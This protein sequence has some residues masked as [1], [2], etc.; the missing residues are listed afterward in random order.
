M[1]NLQENQ[2]YKESFQN[3]QILLPDSDNIKIKIFF[4]LLKSLIF[5]FPKSNVQRFEKSLKFYLGLINIDDCN[6][7]QKPT[8][9]LYLGLPSKPWYEPDDYEVFKIVT[10]TLEEGAKD[11]KSELLM[12]IHN[13]NN[14]TPVIDPS[15]DPIHLLGTDIEL[16]ASHKKDDWS[17][18][19][20][21]LDGKFT[22]EARYLFPKT[23]NILSKLK[24]FIDPFED[25]YFL[26]L[27]PGVVLPPHHDASNAYITC[28]LGLIIPENC[29]I[30]VGSETRSWTEG[31]TLFFDQSFEHEAWNKSQKE[32][33]VLLVHLRHPELSNL[34]NFLYEFVCKSL[35][36]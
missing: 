13:K 18:F 33:V 27:K 10:N 6:P 36:L 30:R 19:R 24:S 16:P 5:L 15:D 17:L 12:N 14:F 31:K 26:V 4:L 25:V 9:F 7:Q 8:L 3:E 32:R 35:S 20:L 21:W 1:A 23:V 34:E 29:G 11:I 2:E 22:Q 28:Q